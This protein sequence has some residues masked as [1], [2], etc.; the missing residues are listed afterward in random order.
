[1]G[2]ELK[3]QGDSA[4]HVKAFQV[5]AV[6]G[7]VNTLLNGFPFQLGKNNAY[8]QHSTTHGRGSVEFFGAGNELH[9]VFLKFCHQIGK[10]QYGSAATVQFIADHPFDSAVPHSLQQPL[11]IR[12]VD[13]FAAVTFVVK[14]FERFSPK[15][16]LAK[17]DLAFDGYTVSFVYGL[18]C[19]DGIG[20]VT[21]PP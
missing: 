1:M 17:F 6:V 14:D 11:K 9:T 10:I 12:T 4:A 8:I 20:H 15:F 19:V 16:I 7:I 13:V 21:T 2:G 3:S 18:P 5:P